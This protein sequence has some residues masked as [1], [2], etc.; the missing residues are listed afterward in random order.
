MGRKERNLND[1]IGLPGPENRGVSANSAQLSF[2]ETA[3]Y[4]FEV[5]LGPNAN[6]F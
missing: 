4:R 6:F 2:T 3:L 1:T 5:S